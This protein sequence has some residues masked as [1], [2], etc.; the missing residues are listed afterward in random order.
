VVAHRARQRL[1]RLHHD[2]ARRRRGGS[3]SATASSRRTSGTVE[4]A[5]PERTAPAC[6]S[7][8]LGI[9]ASQAGAS[10]DRVRWRHQLGQCRTS[11]WS[12][13]VSPS[14]DGAQEAGLLQDADPLRVTEGLA[15]EGLP[16]VPGGIDLSAD[17]GEQPLPAARGGLP[18]RLRHPPGVLALHRG[19]QAPPVLGRLL[20]GFPSGE[21]V[22]GAGGEGEAGLTSAPGRLAWSPHPS[23]GTPVLP[24]WSVLGKYGCS[25]SAVRRLRRLPRPS[26]AASRTATP[27][28]PCTG[29]SSVAWAMPPRHAS[30]PSEI[31]T[32][33]TVRQRG[34]TGRT[35][36]AI[37]GRLPVGRRQP[38]PVRDHRGPGMGDRR[39]KGRRRWS[40]RTGRW[41]FAD[42]ASAQLLRTCLVFLLRERP[43]APETP[44]GS[45]RA[46]V[47]LHV[48]LRV[49]VRGERA[50]AG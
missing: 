42:R 20:V 12:S 10:R 5:R 39:E 17:P 33:R 7:A 30:G 50:P 46:L 37:A 44:T 34:S 14:R 40:T 19:E 25:S 23:R 24:G 22:G 27:C 1:A 38:N 18:H 11:S 13:P 6:A 8:W 15:P 31:V 41:P 43:A 4:L 36:P 48:A 28:R 16:S 9:E 32:V 47:D 2:H 49:Q 3:G 21:P 35:A 45:V 29:R 26:S